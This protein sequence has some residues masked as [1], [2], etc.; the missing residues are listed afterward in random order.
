MSKLSFKTIAF[1]MTCI[2]LVGAI[3]HLIVQLKPLFLWLTPYNLVLTTLIF[4]HLN[5][6]NKKDL[7]TLFIIFL[8]G[9]FVEVIGVKTGLLFGTYNYGE[10]L[11]LKWLDVPLVIGL[12]WVLLN[13]AGHGIVNK[14]LKNTILKSVL[15][16]ILIVLLDVLIEP[17]A[18]Q[19]DY[20]SW[21]N[22]SIPLQNYLMWF[23]VSFVI[24]LLINYSKIK[25]NFK[26]S[27][28][29]ILLQLIF[30]TILNLAL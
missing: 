16:S 20:W 10:S 23:G 24:Q 30:F 5:S 19:I 27:L 3:G 29:M 28:L 8:I 7:L 26:S 21:E 17:V 15:A 18:I 1:L 22:N 14:F 4:L 12:N 13:L 11:G 25:I 2:Y 6:V 9:F